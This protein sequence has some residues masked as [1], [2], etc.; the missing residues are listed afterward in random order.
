MVLFTDNKANKSSVFFTKEILNMSKQHSNNMI[1]TFYKFFTYFILY[2]I[3]ILIFGRI[4]YALFS[5][6]RTFVITSSAF[7]LSIIMM[8]PVYGNFRIGFEKSKP[9][10]LSTMITVFI[11]NVLSFMAMAIMGVNQFPISS[12]ILPGFLALII[13]YIIQGILIWILAHLGNNLYFSLYS[14][15]KTIIIDNNKTLYEK[16][17]RYIKSH[18]KQYDLI[19]TYCKPDFNDIDFTDVDHVF[20]L[21]FDPLFEKEVV[22]YCYYNKIKITYNANTYNILVAKQDSIIIDDALMIEIYPAVMSL[23]QEFVKRIIDVLGASLI[24][25]VTSPIFILVAIAIK[26]DDGGPIFFRQDRLTKDGKIF[27]ITKFRSMKL[28]SGSIPAIKND[29]R[30][31]KVGNI[32]RKFRVDELPQMFNILQGDMSLVGPRP[33]SVAH[34]QVIKQTVP[35]FDQ[36]LKVKAGLTGYAQI[37]G[38]YNT[39]PKMKLR[40]D[41][42]YIESFSILDDIK[43]LL[44]TL[45]VFVRPDSTE[46]FEGEVID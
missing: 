32:I 15:A 40:L 29:T 7:F 27:Q 24:L 14:P 28:D 11:A 26:R 9:V 3:F 25:I 31:T 4:N 23:F 33:E 35:E 45:I 6:T 38:K 30:I 5:L 10:F 22:E 42:K 8:M 39:S 46:A 41:I 12:V 21:N 1:I 19:Q 13:T 34:A 20:L 36:R 43:L 17:S 44:Q 16:I 37:F 18:D 2:S